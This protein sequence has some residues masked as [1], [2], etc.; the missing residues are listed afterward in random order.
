MLDNF[1]LYVFGAI[2][3]I[4][5]FVSVCPADS[6]ARLRAVRLLETRE[7]LDDITLQSLGLFQCSDS[8]IRSQSIAFVATDRDGR[9]VRGAVCCG[10]FKDCTVRFK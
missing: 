5:T 9:R 7:R 6:D 3:L 1:V 2:A 10:W 4:I 8:D